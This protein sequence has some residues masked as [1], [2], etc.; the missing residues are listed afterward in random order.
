MSDLI[1][2]RPIETER[3][4]VLKNTFRLLGL[5]MI[6]TVIGA[7][8]GT[9]IPWGFMAGSPILSFIVMLAVM[10]GFCYG[11]EKNKNNGLGVALMLGLTG[12]FG[13]M[14][15]PALQ[16]ALGMSNG[17]EI[18]AMAAGGTGV[19]FMVLSTIAANTKRDFSNLGAFLFT[20]LIVVIL[21][22]VANMF[23]HSSLA[24]LVI[25]SFS[26]LLFSGFILYDVNRVVQGGETNYV[27]AALNI[28]L[29]IYNMFLHLLN[30]L[31]ALTGN[32]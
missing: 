7:I 17:V 10:L 15:G 26:I 28:Y 9:M 19:A 30:L 31:M 16:H 11:I 2:S 27:I 20:G 1:I 32:D 5:S 23:F 18:I 13:L 8:A 25:S 21:A 22:S 14:A 6:P 4:Q 29:D 24:S 3:N 12:F